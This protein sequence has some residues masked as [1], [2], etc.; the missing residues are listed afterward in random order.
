MKVKEL[1]EK[2]QEFIDEDSNR[3]DWEVMLLDGGYTAERIQVSD[4]YQE[5]I[6]IT[7]W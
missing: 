4:V 7:Q 5:V 6:D 3:A 1:I 2:L